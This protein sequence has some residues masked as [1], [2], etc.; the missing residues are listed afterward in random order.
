LKS[1]PLV[2]TLELGM[3]NTTSRGLNLQLTFLG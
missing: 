1:Y 3:H 2:V